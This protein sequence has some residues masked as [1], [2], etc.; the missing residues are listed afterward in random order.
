MFIMKNCADE[1]FAATS[2]RLSKSNSQLQHIY[3]RNMVKIP[4]KLLKKR[5]PQ[6]SVVE[7]QDENKE[8]GPSPPKKAKVLRSLRSTQKNASQIVDK[9]LTPSRELNVETSLLSDMQ[10]VFNME[11]DL[12]PI[13]NQSHNEPL[14]IETKD[15]E[16]P[17]EKKRKHI[18]KQKQQL[19]KSS[20]ETEG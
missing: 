5:L 15:D 9:T 18:V 17:P 4:E 11:V 16:S 1:L 6:K 19:N 12:P 13:I 14:P 3:K 2:S 10:E 20:S 7:E 8:N